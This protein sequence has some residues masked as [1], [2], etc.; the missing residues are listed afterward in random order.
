MLQGVRDELKLEDFKLCKV[1]YEFYD[2]DWVDTNVSI[3]LDHLLSRKK[4]PMPTEKIDI[5]EFG[6]MLWFC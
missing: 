1:V 3:R 6:I 5:F 2:Q 4:F